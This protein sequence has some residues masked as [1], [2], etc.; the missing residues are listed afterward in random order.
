VQKESSLMLDNGDSISV[1]FVN[2]PKEKVKE[3]RKMKQTDSESVKPSYWQR[4]FLQSKVNGAPYN[5]ETLPGRNWDWPKDTYFQRR[6][7]RIK[8]SSTCLTAPS[9]N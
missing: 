1:V 6:L 4:I 3:G 5:G 7:H 8:V 2:R 9:F